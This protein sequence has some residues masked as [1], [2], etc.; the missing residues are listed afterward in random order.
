MFL[1]QLK[2][3]GVICRQDE[4]ARLIPGYKT[5]YE[6]AKA[7]IAAGTDVAT[8]IEKLKNEAKVI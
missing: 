4:A 3:G 8:L 2:T 1:S 7:A 5:T 6:L